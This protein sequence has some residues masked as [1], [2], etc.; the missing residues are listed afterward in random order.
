MHMEAGPLR[1]PGPDFGVLV[2][3]VVV[4]DQVQ[5]Q[6]L[7]HLLV[8]PSQEAEELLMTVAGLALSDHCTGGHIQRREQRGGAVADVV[9]GDALHVA[10]AH[11]QQRLGAVQCLDLR[12][13]VN[14][15]H[16]R[17]DGRVQVQA[18]DV[19][20]LLDKERIGGD[21]EV[22]LPVGLD[23]ESLQP[24]VDGGFGDPRGSGQRARAPVGAAIGRFGLESSVDHLRDLVV[25]V[26]ARPART[27]LIMQ[28]FQAELQV[29][30]APL[31]DGHARQTQP[32]GDG[33]VGFASTAGQHDLGA[34]HDRMGQ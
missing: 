9:V 29:A 6:I 19:A 17:L 4:H 10:Q 34:L 16:H 23:R 1:Q 14:A 31:A 32:F 21:L 27:E 7:G 12:L 18:R 15:E 13:L 8:D 28:T 24:A 5:L 25:F 3:A 33:G 30:L 11:R 22:L 2:G 20:D 26:S